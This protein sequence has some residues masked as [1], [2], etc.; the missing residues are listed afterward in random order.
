MREGEDARLSPVEEWK[1]KEKKGRAITL[2]QGPLLLL[3]RVVQVINRLQ[4]DNL[5]PLPFR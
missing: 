3:V 2:N 1:G 4:E 5:I